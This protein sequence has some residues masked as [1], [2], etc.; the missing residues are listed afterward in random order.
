MLNDPKVIIHMND[1]DKLAKV[2]RSLYK[3]AYVDK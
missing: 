3:V 2:D 1:I